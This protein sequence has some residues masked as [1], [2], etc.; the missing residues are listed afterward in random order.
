MYYKGLIRNTDFNRTGT[1]SVA[2]PLLTTN[3][4][5]IYLPDVTYDALHKDSKT[6]KTT[7]QNLLY[8]KLSL[9]VDD[10]LYFVSHG[11]IPEFL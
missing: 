10:M 7:D 9:F 3:S 8:R 6:Y 1:N 5:A 4:K 2:I 11:D